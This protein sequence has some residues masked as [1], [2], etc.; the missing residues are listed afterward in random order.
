MI[1][2]HLFEDEPLISVEIDLDVYYSYTP[3]KLYGRPEDCYPEEEEFEIVPEKDYA[4]RI[5]AAY[6]AEARE[7]IKRFE[8]EIESL[9]NNQT[10][11]EWAEAA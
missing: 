11:R 1:R 7:A 8:A 5:M 4:E 6:V 2:Q 9:A 3:A 10:V